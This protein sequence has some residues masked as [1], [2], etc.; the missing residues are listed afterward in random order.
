MITLKTVNKVLQEKHPN[1]ELVKGNGYFYFAG[2]DA[3]KW[4]SSTVDIL[5]IND[6]TLEQWIEDFETMKAKYEKNH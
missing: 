4:Y 5:R 2:V 3:D 6:Q 1:N